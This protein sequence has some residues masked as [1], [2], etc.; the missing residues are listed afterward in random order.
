MIQLL[1]LMWGSRA[2]RRKWWAVL[3]LGVFW[4]GLGVF[5][6]VN[7]LKP[8]SRI[9]A[10]YFTIPLII[11]A[12]WSLL[13]SFSL[14]GT[15]RKLRMTKAVVFL[16][17]ILLIFTSPRYS[18]V[19]IGILAGLFLM[20]D[21][22][23]R[24]ASAVV[25]QFE[26]W[27]RSFVFAVVEFGFGV[28]SVVPW[29]TYWEGAVGIDVGTLLL[30]S[31]AGVCGLALRIRTLSPDMS[32]LPAM[33]RGWANALRV[34]QEGAPLPLPEDAAKGGTAVVHVWTPT[35]ALAPVNRGIRRYVAAPDDRGIISTGHAALELGDDVYI[36]HYP[37]VEIDRTG[38]EFTRILRATPDNDVDGLFQPSY[39]Q[40]SADWCPSTMRVP[41]PGLNVQAIREFW[42]AYRL[43][44]TYN[45]TNRNCSSVVAK[46][47]D[48]GL[49]GLFEKK[50]SLAFLV[51][52]L[53]TTEFIVAGFM[54]H[55]AAAMAWTPGILL[56]YAR[57]LSYILAM[58]AEARRGADREETA[59]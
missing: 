6:I 24:G 39:A 17:V 20:L 44:S 12:A 34:R 49:D 52:L 9:P 15:A 10:A 38:T 46:A 32:I 45:L 31:G 43:D 28:W 11:D 55:R 53:F 47:L 41:L 54:R 8:A 29:P 18:G 56:D 50:M 1:L 2:V 37:A 35:S 3:L 4:T 14:Y 48:A 19:I 23:W 13:S 58:K 36:S 57:A 7:A 40:E 5:C 26:G 27:R 51:R 22:S 59:G 21:A 42:A 16:C 30:L 25:V 33:S